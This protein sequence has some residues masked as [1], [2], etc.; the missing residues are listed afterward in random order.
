MDDSGQNSNLKTQISNDAQVTQTVDDTQ[1][2]PVQQP[3]AP[4]PQAPPSGS[5]HKEAGPVASAVEYSMTPSEPNETRPELD[6]EVQDAGVEHAIN[7]ENLQLTEEHAKAGIEPAKESVPMQAQLFSSTVGSTTT[8]IKN[9]PFTTEEANEIL[10]TT[11]TNDTKHWLAVLFLMVCK[12]M[13]L[14]TS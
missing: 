14:I 11:P 1:Q 2:Q 10:K 8:Q 4:T 13:N 3:V 12:K 7:P 9:P 5:M 6:Q